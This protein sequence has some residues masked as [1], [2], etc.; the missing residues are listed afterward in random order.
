MHCSG[1]Y[2][3][4]VV[5][6]SALLACAA[7]FAFF[8]LVRARF[9]AADCLPVCFHIQAAMTI[10]L[11]ISRSTKAKKLQGRRQKGKLQMDTSLFLFGCSRVSRPMEEGNV[12]G[13]ARQRIWRAVLSVANSRCGICATLVKIYEMSRRKRFFA[14]RAWRTVLGN[15]SHAV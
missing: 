2:T 10:S 4:A 15:A 6:L 1:D 8:M 5:V 14:R 13:A 7:V 3:P 9:N 11:P 12:S